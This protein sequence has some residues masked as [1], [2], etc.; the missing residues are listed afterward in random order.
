MKK[1]GAER[2]RGLVSFMMDAYPMFWKSS[3]LVTYA[4]EFGRQFS[5]RPWQNVDRIELTSAFNADTSLRGLLP[6]FAFSGKHYDSAVK[7]M[8][9]IKVELLAPCA[10]VP[11]PEDEV[12]VQVATAF[13]RIAS[14]EFG[15]NEIHQIVAN[16]FVPTDDVFVRFIPSLFA[17][18]AVKQHADRENLLKAMVVRSLEISSPIHG[19]LLDLMSGDIDARQSPLANESNRLML[20]LPRP[21]A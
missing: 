16:T 1:V 13:L 14:R 5:Y 17:M 20:Q 19:K 11:R 6:I 9:G 7:D 21:L 15:A 2:R 3:S 12:P 10:L 8:D 18:Q 4:D